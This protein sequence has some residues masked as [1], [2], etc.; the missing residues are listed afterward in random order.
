MTGGFTNPPTTAK[1]PEGQSLAAGFAFKKAAQH[2]AM[3]YNGLEPSD[4]KRAFI[5]K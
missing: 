1:L 4:E 3:R 5:C 2:S